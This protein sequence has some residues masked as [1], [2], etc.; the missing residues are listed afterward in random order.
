MIAGH[1]PV[2]VGHMAP[3]RQHVVRAL[4]IVLKHGGDHILRLTGL[5]QG[6]K[7]MFRPVRIPQREHGIVRKPFSMMQFMIKAPIE[8]VHVHVH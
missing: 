8:A 4:L 6:E 3:D 2:F 1:A 5:E 7:R